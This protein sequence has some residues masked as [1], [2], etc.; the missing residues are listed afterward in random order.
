ML[1]TKNLCGRIKWV[2]VKSLADNLPRGNFVVGWDGLYFVRLVAGIPSS[3]GP[4]SLY[5][6]SLVKATLGH[7]ASKL[8]LAA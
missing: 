1:P 6:Q 4:I 7:T 3:T 2:G 5:C 8:V